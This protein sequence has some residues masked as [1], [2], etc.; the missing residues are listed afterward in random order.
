MNEK[1]KVEAKVKE[2]GGKITRREFLGFFILGGFL[3]IF[4]KKIKSEKKLKKAMF[5]RKADES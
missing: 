4:F 5:W 1:V 2:T 3:S